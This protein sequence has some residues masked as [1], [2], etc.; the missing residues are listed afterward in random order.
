MNDNAVQRISARITSVHTF[1]HQS[2]SSLSYAAYFADEGRDIEAAN[3]DPH[4]GQVHDFGR[5]HACV[6]AS[7]FTAVASIEASVNELFICAHEDIDH[8]VPERVA[9]RA[10]LK[11][12]WQETIRGGKSTGILSG[13][14]KAYS[15]ALGCIS[16][17]NVALVAAAK[18]GGISSGGGVH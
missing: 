14:L 4:T 13:I 8:L 1:H 9:V 15:V 5:I 10:K 7:I 12:K 11:Q 6:A 2:A 17:G 18:W 16:N 3:T